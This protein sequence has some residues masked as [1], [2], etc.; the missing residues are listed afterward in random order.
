[1]LLKS[2]VATELAFTNQGL[3]VL[4]PQEAAVTGNANVTLQRPLLTEPLLTRTW[5]DYSH[6]RPTPSTTPLTQQVALVRNK[7]CVKLRLSGCLSSVI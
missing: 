4:S 5:S 2:G 6:Q 3:F 1:M 7:T